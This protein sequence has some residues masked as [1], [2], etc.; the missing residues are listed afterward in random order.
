MSV[1]T[2]LP[3]PSFREPT[4]PFGCLRTALPNQM[5][6][7]SPNYLQL[8]PG[9][10]GA[11]ITGEGAPSNAS[12]CSLWGHAWG[13]PWNGSFLGDGKHNRRSYEL[14]PILRYV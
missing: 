12:P 14:N 11:P 5:C 1:H 2:M 10:C 3:G 8:G 4:Y 9:V 7:I 6:K 13:I